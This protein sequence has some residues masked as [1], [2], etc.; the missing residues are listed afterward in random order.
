MSDTGSAAGIQLGAHSILP[1]RREPLS[2]RTDDGIDLVGELS[3]P[4]RRAPQATLVMLHPLPTEGGSSDSH[5]YRKAAWRLPALA[6][7]AIL[8]FNTRGTTSSLGRSAGQFDKGWSERFDLA[9]A[10]SHAKALGLPRLWLVGWSFGSEVALMHG[11]NLPVEGAVLLSPPLKRAGPADL[12]QWAACRLPLVALV[13]EHDQFLGPAQARDRF[14]LASQVRV[15]VGPGFGHLWIG[16]K[17]VHWAL[18]ELTKAVGVRAEPLP[19]SWS[20]P[21]SQYHPQAG[22]VTP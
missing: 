18:S 2:F 17:A 6:D 20:G 13:P 10:V 4:S 15:V 7:L 19:K 9:A 21:V 22:K 16:E 8:R 1:A 3:L 12:V 14:R 5:L 11:A